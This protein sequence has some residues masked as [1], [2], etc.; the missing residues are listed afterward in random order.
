MP[1]SRQRK[2]HKS[3]VRNY[4]ES[5]GAISKTKEIGKPREKLSFNLFKS[6]KRK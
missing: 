3:K 6:K 4:R 2:K 5:I 1:K